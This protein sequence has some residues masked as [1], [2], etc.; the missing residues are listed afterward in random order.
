[1][2]RKGWRRLKKIARKEIALREFQTNISIINNIMRLSFIPLYGQN[3]Y[4]TSCCGVLS[5]LILAGFWSVALW[6]TAGTIEGLWEKYVQYQSIFLI[7]RGTA[8]DVKSFIF[9]NNIIF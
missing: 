6:H 3:I 2:I 9:L 5:K 7:K 1:M 4:K 8:G